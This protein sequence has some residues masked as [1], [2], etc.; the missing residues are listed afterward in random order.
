M[1]FIQNAH[2]VQVSFLGIDTR[3]SLAVTLLLTLVAGAV[4]M[5]VIAGGRPDGR[6]GHRP[7][8]P[9]APPATHWHL[10][11]TVPARPVS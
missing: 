8:C 4:L 2:V 6:G 3:L 5:T 9:T 10:P 7:D 1:I 11:P